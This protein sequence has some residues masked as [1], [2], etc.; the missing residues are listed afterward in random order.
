MELGATVATGHGC[1]SF[2]FM[3]SFIKHHLDDLMFFLGLP[4]LGAGFYFVYPPLG[5]IVP[6][7][8]L[9]LTGLFMALRK[10]S[11]S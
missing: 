8:V 3:A 5:L 10:G 1:A 7:A 4:M 6:G 2:V 11:Q 9:V